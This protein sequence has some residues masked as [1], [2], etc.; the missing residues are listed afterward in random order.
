MHYKDESDIRNIK[1][2]IHENVFDILK[3]SQQ[4]AEQ[5]IVNTYCIRR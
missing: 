4:D 1:H 2:Y 3:F 5:L